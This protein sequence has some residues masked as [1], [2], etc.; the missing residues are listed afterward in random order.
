M[1]APKRLD[2]LFPT[3]AE[4]PEA[5][6]PDAPIEQREYLV[7]GQLRTSGWPLGDGP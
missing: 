3:L 5:Y 4:I 1:T 2:T 6:R 7:D